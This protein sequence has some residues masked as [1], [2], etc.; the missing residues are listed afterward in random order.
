M[1]TWVPLCPD[2]R[3]PLREGVQMH[4]PPNLADSTPDGTVSCRFCGGTVDVD[5]G[6]KWARVA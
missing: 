2:C 5:E 4:E 6:T 3:V 1:A